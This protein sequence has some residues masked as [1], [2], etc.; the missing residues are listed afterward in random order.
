MKYLFTILAFV[1]LSSAVTLFYIWPSGSPKTENVAL[2]VNGH[3]ISRENLDEQIRKNGYHSEDEESSINSFVIR[4][5]LLNEA[6]RLGIDKEA[7]FR[8]AIKEYYEQSLIKVLTDRKLQSLTVTINEDAIDRYLSCSG[9]IFTFTRIPLKNGKLLDEQK[10]QNSVLFDDLSESLRLV[11]AN[12]NPGEK[13]SQ[14]E[15]GTEVGV[16][17][18]DKVERADGIDPVSYERSRVMEIL[19][20]YQKSLEVDRWINTLRKEAAVVVYKEDGKDE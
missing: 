1:A 3:G 6:Q 10:H 12:L 14:F 13:I 7:E 11:L 9:K 8:D 19:T 15:T 18:L 17:I 2:S 5:L 20:N 4:Q 16:V